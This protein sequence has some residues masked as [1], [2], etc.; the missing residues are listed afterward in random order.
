VEVLCDILTPNAATQSVQVAI[1]TYNQVAVNPINLDSTF[2]SMVFSKS[3][4]ITFVGVAA[5]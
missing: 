5:S 1:D 4:I 2:V 3:D